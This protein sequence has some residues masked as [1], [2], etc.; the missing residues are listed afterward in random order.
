MISISAKL[1]GNWDIDG[2]EVQVDCPRCGFA[3][4]VWLKQI[5]LRERRHLSW[6]QVQ[7]ST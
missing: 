6:L 3:N 4:P 5:R 7:H 2:V 1:E